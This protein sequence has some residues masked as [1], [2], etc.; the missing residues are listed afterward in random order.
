MYQFLDERDESVKV[1]LNS[2]VELIL[3]LEV[4]RH[5]HPLAR[6]PLHSLQ[7]HKPFRYF[8]TSSMVISFPLL[9]SPPSC[10]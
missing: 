8:P 2:E 6:F 1:L 3:F 9:T 5:C 10:S 4:H 7:K